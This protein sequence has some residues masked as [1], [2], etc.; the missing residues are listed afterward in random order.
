MPLPLEYH[1]DGKYNYSTALMF[2]YINIFKPKK[3][4][5]DIK[6][7]S[8]N[9]Y[10][11]CWENNVRPID[12]MNDIK[13]KKYADEVKRIKKS[14]TKFPIIIDTNNNIIDGVHRYIKYILNKKKTINVIMFD[15]KM[16]KKFIISKYNEKKECQICN[17]I[18][19]FIK[20]FIK[21]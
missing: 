7:L 8:F 10:Y 1:S 18:E 21:L 15:E 20:R 2:S 9:L 4:K 16:M 13:N 19:L 3:V 12:V 17:I 11:E 6:K 5:L 14:D